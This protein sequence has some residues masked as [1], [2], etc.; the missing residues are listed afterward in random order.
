MEINL[1]KEAGEL[2]PGEVVEENLHV[3]DELIDKGNS[4]EQPLEDEEE[5]EEEPE[6]EDGDG[7]SDEED[8]DDDVQVNTYLVILS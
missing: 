6:R 8:S 5:E 2:S 4:D 7:G 3:V 1:E